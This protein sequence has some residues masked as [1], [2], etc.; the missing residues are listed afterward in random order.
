MEWQTI[1]SWRD[2]GFWLPLA[3]ALV[4][5]LALALGSELWVRRYIQGLEFLQASDPEAAAAAAERGLRLLG[6]VVCGFSLVSSAVLGRY[7]QSGAS[8]ATA[9]P[10]GL[11][12]SWRA[13]GRGGFQ[14]PLAK[15][16]RVGPLHF[17]RGGWNWLPSRH[18]SS[19]RGSL[20]EACRL[21]RH[22]S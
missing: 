19:A 3:S 20:G 17:A 10:L 12:E 16:L 7:F 1:P 13:P 4:L 6:R 21:T 14:C 2:R 15:S 5:V 18:E 8:R 11:V 9:S 22:W